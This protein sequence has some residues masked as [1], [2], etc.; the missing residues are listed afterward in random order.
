MP[1]MSGRALRD[2]QADGH[3]AGELGRADDVLLD[4][5]AQALGPDRRLLGRRVRAQDEEFLAA[6]AR[7]VLSLARV[8]AQDV[9]DLAQDDVPHLVAVDVVH[10]LE[11]VDVDHHRGERGGGGLGALPLLGQAIPDAAPVR[12]AGQRIGQRGRAQPSIQEPELPDLLRD[13]LALAVHLAL[14]LDDPLAGA[15]AREQD[16]RVEGLRDVFVDPGVVGLDDLVLRV[17][18][19]EEQKEDLAAALDAAQSLA[20]LDPVHPRHHPVRD[21]GLEV[22]LERHLERFG[23]VGGAQHLVAFLAED[24]PQ[25]EQRGRVVVYREDAQASARP[26]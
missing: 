13:D 7:D 10:A 18:P 16:P 4:C 12:Q 8:R 20:Q 17:A 26:E 22:V 11:G 3:R 15:Q 23:P 1:F 14:Q 2:A 5:L 6:E 24:A 19:R 21:D 25:Q 9:G